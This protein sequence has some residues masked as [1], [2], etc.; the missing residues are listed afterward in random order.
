MAYR[1]RRSLNPSLLSTYE[2]ADKQYWSRRL[3]IGS[4]SFVYFRMNLNCG[5]Y[6]CSQIY[7][8]YFRNQCFKQL[9]FSNCFLVYVTSKTIRLV[10]RGGLLPWKN[11]IVCVNSDCM[12]NR[13]FR[14]CYRCK[15]WPPSE[16][17]FSPL[18]SHGPGNHTV[19][20]TYEFLVCQLMDLVVILSM[21][22]LRALKV[23]RKGWNKFE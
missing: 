4:S 2:A 19:V 12:H 15:I 23:Q 5:G 21:T 18:V 16:N 13:R 1:A 17:S 11:V 8:T 9:C 20:S 10:I 14:T 3:S 22:W 7:Q 6:H